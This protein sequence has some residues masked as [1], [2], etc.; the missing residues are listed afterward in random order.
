[1]TQREASAGTR[2]FTLARLGHVVE[3]D[4]HENPER[5]L[6]DHV[7]PVISRPS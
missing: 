6:H 4:L 1:M 5:S 7:T 2:L 3:F